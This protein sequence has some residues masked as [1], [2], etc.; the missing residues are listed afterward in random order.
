MLSEEFKG[1]IYWNKYKIIFKNYDNEYI[2]ERLYTSIQGVNRLFVLAYAYGNNVTNEN[3]FRKYFLPR[4]KIK[5]YNIKIDGRNFCDQP[6]NDLIKQYNEGKKISTGQGD[7]Y[8]TGCLLDFAYF[9][10]NYRLI[11]ADLNKQKA[12]DADLRAIHQIIFTGKTDN[13]IRVYYIL[14]QSKETILEFSKGTTKVL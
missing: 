6:N 2:R 10:K 8:T 5:N 14:E 9:E 1:S 13:T 12:L 11:V 7:D 3:S 4:F